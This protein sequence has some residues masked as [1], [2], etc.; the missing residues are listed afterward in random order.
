MLAFGHTGL[1]LGSAVV[2]DAIFTVTTRSSHKVTLPGE[3]AV[4]PITINPVDIRNKWLSLLRKYVDLRI[5]FIGSLL[6]DIIDKPLGIYILGDAFSNGR[7][8]SHTLVFF[9]AISLAG[10]LVYWKFCNTW[11]TVLAFGTLTHL[12]LDSQWKRPQTLFWPFLGFGFP[13]Y[14]STDWVQN[15]LKELLTKPSYYVPEILGGLVLAGLTFILIKR[16]RV[17]AFI[18]YGKLL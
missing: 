5:L 14:D 10:G 9:L 17:S 11:L 15:T 8:F 7:I 4:S 2:I 1:T 18:K 13:R 6:P 3:Q 12:I 16:R